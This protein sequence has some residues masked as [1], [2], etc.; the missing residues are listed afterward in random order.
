MDT[1]AYTKSASLSLLL[2][3]YFT[4]TKTPY[5]DSVRTGDFLDLWNR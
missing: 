2:A 5:F 1:Y 4:R 3:K